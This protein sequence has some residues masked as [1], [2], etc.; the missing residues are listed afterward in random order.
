[1]STISFEFED[2]CAFFTKDPT[3][4]MV[5][6]ISTDNEAPQDVHRPHIIIKENGVVRREYH[7]FSEINGDISVDV[8]PESKPFTHYTPRSARA[9]RQSFD[10]VVDIQKDLYPGETL[11]ADAKR[12]RARLHFN[13]GTLYT[14]A[15]AVNAVFA[16]SKTNALIANTPS[17]VATKAGLDIEVP[18]D[19]Y[20]VLHF[21]GDTE[22]FVFKGGRNYQVEV[23]NRADAIDFNHFHFFYNIV[24]PKPKHKLIPIS[25]QGVGANVRAGNWMCLVGNFSKS[26]YALPGGKKR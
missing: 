21:H 12:C 18:K 6:L 24:T 23:T 11:N 17:T 7:N 5:G 10:T 19:G 2:L 25:A 13:S 15:H 8:Y 20:A 22:D 16:D 1:M 14:S 3:R 9:S 4:L 26:E